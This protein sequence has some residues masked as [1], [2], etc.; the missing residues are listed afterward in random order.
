MPGRSEGSGRA[1]DASTGDLRAL[2]AA[3]LA[4]ALWWAAP[5][6][7]PAWALL[8]TAGAVLPWVAPAWSLVLIAA[9]APFERAL[10]LAGFTVY[11]TELLL[12]AAVPAAVGAW[13][14]RPAWRRAAA[15]FSVWATPF[16]AAVLISAALAGTPAALK[17]ALRWLEVG[18]ALWLCVHWLRRGRDAE[19]VLWAVVA[20]ATLSALFGLAQVLGGPAAHPALPLLTVG[21]VELTRAAAEYGPNTLALLLALVLPFIGAAVRC[22]PRR[23]RR[24]LALAA[25]LLCALG[26]AATWSLTAGAALTAGGVLTLLA[27]RRRR[28]GLGVA[29]AAGG[30]VLALAALG[31]LSQGFWDTKL[32]SFQ[33]RLDYLR[34]AEQVARSAPAFGVGPG[35]YRFAAPPFSAGVNPVGVLTHPHSLYL[36]VWAELGAAGLAA[37]LWGLWRAAAFLLARARRLPAGWAAAGG[38]SLLAG[39]AAFAL[40]NST[41]HGLIHDRGVHAALVLGAALVWARR[42]PRPL[43]GERSR[44]FAG[45]WTGEPQPA[46]PDR[47]LA[48]RGRERAPLFELVDL[49]LAGRTSARVLELGCGPAWD[50]LALSL[51]PGLEV[52]ALDRTRPALD[53]ARGTAARLGRPLVLHHGD[54]RRTGLPD[55]SFDLV[56]S[57]GLLEH[58]PDP[59]PVW[60]ETARLLKPGGHAIV[61]VPQ[62][63]NPYTLAKL[64]HRLRG[65]WAWGWETQYT[66]GGLSAEARRT[67]LRPVAA[68]GYGYRGGV[69]DVTARVRDLC[70]KLRPDAWARWERATG[71]WWMMN[72][73]M[74]FRKP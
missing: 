24:R 68:R 67:G 46:D 35:G 48:E 32:A 57:Q 7:L 21:R 45:V 42:A 15:P 38:W 18:W 58:F 6:S 73:V 47:M 40:G 12:A 56:F 55:G 65:D 61:D 3:G 43:R 27:A 30:A 8:A 39:L 37:L 74:L 16:F 19:R 11:S 41:E 60:A 53:L 63:W 14:A 54:A 44:R 17:G 5:G 4:A 10:G 51:R 1:P 33:D 29:F 72:L 59:D 25:G 70:A 2:L 31:V 26:L 36:T 64:W 66:C 50:A 34:I 13:F 49:A 23:S 9:T 62:A 71:K 69:L 22:H 52:H 20:A 28:L